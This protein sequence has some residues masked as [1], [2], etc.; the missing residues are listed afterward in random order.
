MLRE[1]AVQEALG[2]AST[3]RGAGDAAAG[4]VG[5]RVSE[6]AADEVVQ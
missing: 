2:E 3:E 1:G 4:E 6:A 5:A